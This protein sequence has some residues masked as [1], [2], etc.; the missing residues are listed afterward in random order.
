M[1][2]LD[3]LGRASEQG[4]TKPITPD[5]LTL[6]DVEEFQG[7]P[8]FS[9]A[10]GAPGMGGEP[11][12]P[13]HMQGYAAVLHPNETGEYSEADL[14]SY[15]QKAKELGLA[16]LL[17]GKLPAAEEGWSTVAK[18][19]KQKME[20]IGEQDK[21]A[22]SN[23]LEAIDKRQQLVATYLEEHPAIAAA[24]IEASKTGD[25]GTSYE[26]E[27]AITEE[28]VKVYPDINQF[29]VTP[30]VKELWSD[31]ELSPGKRPGML[32][33]GAQQYFPRDFEVLSKL[34]KTPA[35]KAL[36][37]TQ[38]P[39][40]EEWVKTTEATHGELGRAYE[41]MLYQAMSTGTIGNIWAKPDD[42]E[43]YLPDDLV[44]F[45]AGMVMSRSPDSTK[46]KHH[47][48]IRQ[49][50]GEQ[51]AAMGEGFG[52]GGWLQQKEFVRGMIPFGEQG[53]FPQEELERREKL[54][55]LMTLA[56]ESTSG[57]RMAGK[58]TGIVG[59][60]GLGYAQLTRMGLTSFFGANARPVATLM[61]TLPAEAIIDAGYNKPGYSM[62]LG[63]LLD[64]D[65]NRIVSGVESMILGTL[66]NLGIDF[67]RLLKGKR[68]A[69]LH[70]TL[71]GEV[72]VEQKR[73]LEVLKRKAV[74]R[75]HMERKEWKPRDD[76]KPREPTTEEIVRAPVVEPPMKPL[77]VSP[78]TQKRINTFMGETEAARLQ[79]IHGM[80]QALE[81]VDTMISRALMKGPKLRPKDLDLVRKQLVD[82]IAVARND[83]PRL[84]RETR[85]AAHAEA[86]AMMEAGTSMEARGRIKSYQEKIGLKEDPY[87]P[88]PLIRDE[89]S[90]S[91]DVMKMLGNALPE[92]SAMDM[93][94]LA[95]ATKTE[96][97]F[98]LFGISRGMA[99]EAL[100]REM[101]PQLGLGLLGGGWSMSN[102]E[103]NKAGAFFAGMML[104]LAG[105]GAVKG[106]E[107]FTMV[108][109][110]ISRTYHEVSDVLGY[111]L[112]PLLSTTKRL[113]PPVYWGML[114]NRFRIQMET[115][116]RQEKM[117]AFF[118]HMN[119]MVSGGT[120]SEKT[121][122]AIYDALSD[123]RRDFALDEFKRIDSGKPKQWRGVTKDLF[124]GYEDV[125]RKFSDQADEIGFEMGRIRDVPYFPRWIKTDKYDEFLKEIG[126]VEG[127]AVEK[128]WEAWAKKAGTTVSKLT[129]AEKA[130]IANTVISTRGW[131]AVTG[132]PSNAL[133]RKFKER[134][135]E[136]K[137]L[138]EPL[139][140][141]SIR[142][143]NSMTTALENHRFLGQGMTTSWL[144]EVVELAPGI[145]DVAPWKRLRIGPKKRK[146][147]LEESIG[148]KVTKMLEGHKQLS[149]RQ[150]NLLVKR[151][152]QFYVKPTGGAMRGLGKFLRDIGYMMTIGNPYST[153]TQIS[154]VFLSASLNTRGMGGSMLATAARRL[155]G[156]KRTYTLDD[157]GMDPDGLKRLI[158][159]F[160]DEGIMTKWL[161]KNLKA[162]GFTGVDKFGKATLM[163]NTL[164]ELRAA[165]A[166]PR[167]TLKFKAL[168]D[169]FA[170]AMGG[171]DGDE[172]KSL[173]K[174][175]RL[176]E[177]EAAKNWTVKSAIWSRML[178]QAPIAPEAMP[179]GYSKH[180]RFR[181]MYMLKSFTVKQI[182]LVRLRVFDEFKKGWDKEGL[183]RKGKATKDL[184]R[185]LALFGGSQQG[186]NVLKDAALG[187]EV[188]IHDRTVSWAAQSMG[189]HRMYFHMF[190]DI[191]A[192]EGYGS[193][194][195]KIAAFTWK[196]FL[197]APYHIIVDKAWPDFSDAMEGSLR[198]DDPRGNELHILGQRTGIPDKYV[199]FLKARMWRHLPGLGPDIFWTIGAGREIEAQRGKVGIREKP[200]FQQ[201]PKDQP[202]FPRK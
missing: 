62:V 90:N 102:S 70:E 118:G 61:A 104:P 22:H 131:D 109:K 46:H 150:Q 163:D 160:E 111:N 153:A 182:D 79:R 68:V 142:Y 21:V 146:Q 82:H 9:Y 156:N 23:Y 10:P 183:R 107:A 144:D 34:S 18:V 158:A 161:Q 137:H 124:L 35:A 57:A 196:F 127:S 36:G 29:E 148:A 19:P 50:I 132:K 41:E 179:L 187:R 28:L 126:K 59:T 123:G 31:V 11:Q 113:A 85:E 1:P 78:E 168:Q 87:A 185:Y 51:V 128:T 33:K 175:L 93:K 20:G 192:D 6:K 71:M 63:A 55:N 3:I 199:P 58:I 12:D 117:E 60:A 174:A 72:G 165:A 155:T 74:K 48:A 67:M 178:D 177:K 172:F 115:F 95:K 149:V 15:F 7:A 24:Y 171:V 65:Q 202:K 80:E 180:P 147:Q 97:P 81:N 101:M 195:E 86:K 49:R 119:D 106:L 92:S 194:G 181:L 91:S 169:E 64:E 45:Y 13:R 176:P 96:E 162:V 98:H 184:F 88:P 16:P 198:R 167:K 151:L 73:V 42:K 191:M 139:D 141:A 201:K 134:P 27:D 69:K 159:E 173:I 105:P 197:P 54:R 2:N 112:V 17:A 154:D 38:V 130:H 193:R 170:E 143:V 94:A 32:I 114:E 66:F 84:P 44:N 189:L 103:Q 125:I 136:L 138:W 37:V 40:P 135:P 99:R 140:K 56:G 200:M 116:H 129:R 166:A 108:G 83:R 152:H 26:I 5:P 30:K 76:S 14:M 8:D 145:K 43:N 39:P 75:F 110:G 77:P 52:E 120:I 25:K 186:I 188:S 122:L 47:K 4:G 89:I 164:Y 157:F 100:R 133:T 53:G 190:N 121:K